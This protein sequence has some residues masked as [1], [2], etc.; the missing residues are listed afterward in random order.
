MKL[1]HLRPQELPVSKAIQDTFELTDVRDSS[2]PIGTLTMILRATC[3]G[4]L[5]VTQLQKYGDHSILVKGTKDDALYECESVVRKIPT[6]PKLLHRPRTPCGLDEK[7]LAQEF[8]EVIGDGKHVCED[9][10]SMMKPIPC[11]SGVDDLQFKSFYDDCNRLCVVYER[12]A[13]SCCVPDANGLPPLVQDDHVPKPQPPF[14]GRGNDGPRFVSPP[15]G[16]QPP[17]ILKEHPGNAEGSKG[18]TNPV[19]MAGAPGPSQEPSAHALG[20]RGCKDCKRPRNQDFDFCPVYPDEA[21]KYREPTANEKLGIRVCEAACLPPPPGPPKKEE[22]EEKPVERVPRTAAAGRAVLLER[23][24]N[25]TK[26]SLPKTSKQKRQPVKFLAP[27]RP[28]PENP[29]PPEW[30]ARFPAS[31]PYSATT[32]IHIRTPQEHQKHVFV[33]KMQAKAEPK[34]LLQLELRTPRRPQ[35]GDPP[36]APPEPPAPPPPPP[37]KKGKAKGKGKGKGK[38]KKGKK[39]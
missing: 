14:E 21:R 8:K 27:S 9:C 34:P 39:K 32:D 16:Y 22:K 13:D 20:K 19:N 29:E 36:P 1:S 7:D 24:M 6:G 12:D 38:G 3:L 10:A 35:P 23:M 4:K 18:P 2:R 17:P 25:T 30:T 11:G 28:P 37:A 15:P 5:V 26:Q 31:Q 33:M